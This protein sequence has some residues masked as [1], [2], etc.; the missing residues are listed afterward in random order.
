[1][2]TVLFCGGL[3]TRIRDYSESIPKPMIPIGG[4][5]ILWHL[6]HTYSQYGHKDFILCLGYKANVI[7]EFFL[8]YRPQTYADCIVSGFGDHVEILGDAQADWRIAMIDT[9][10]W[11]N[12]GQRLLAVREHVENEEMF[13]ANYS[14][15]LCDVH[16]PE[17]IEA[18]RRSGKIACFLAVR[19]LFSLHFV[20]LETSGR[21]L[22]I[23][24]T[25]S[26]NL[27]VNGGFFIFRPQIFEYMREG[28][29]LVGPPFERLIEADQILAFKHEGFWRPMDTL[30]DKQ[31]LEDLV[32]RGEMPWRVCGKVSAASA[33][34]RSQVV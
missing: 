11:R 8:N 17:M 34:V 9:G 16:L 5:P 19:P 30:N 27:W 1:M 24:S 25:Q 15:G 7:K 29:E 31:V 20:D 2:K 23:H 3:G 13:F 12:I 21:V 6:M 26:A 10:I 32:E 28:D 33:D 22:G 18:F 14:D 4:K